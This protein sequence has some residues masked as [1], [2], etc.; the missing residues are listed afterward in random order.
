[1]LP[2]VETG[3]RYDTVPGVVVRRYTTGKRDRVV[4]SVAGVGTGQR[5][6]VHNNSLNNLMRGLAER[7]LFKASPGGLVKAPRPVSGAFNRLRGVKHLLLKHLSP[8][9]VVDLDDYPGL[10][11]GRKRVIYERAVAELHSR[12]YKDSGAEIKAFVKAEK[13]NFTAKGD[14]APRLI[15]P[16]SPVYNACLGRYLK[17]F[18]KRLF[19][20]F[21]AA[22]GYPVVL[23][24]LNADGVGRALET[25]WKSFVKPVA[26]GLDASRFDQH[27]SQEALRFEHSVYNSVFGSPELAR[28]L[29]A[30][31]RNKGIGVA[32]DGHVRYKTD[33]C[34]MSGDINTGMGNC[35]LM[36][37]MVLGYC[38]SKHLRALLS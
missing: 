12:G 32:A 31:L 24:G 17:K 35:L 7:V 26:V 27:V 30:Q 19:R 29:R 22:F 8:T 2:G 37:L 6:G 25:N 4:R 13:I 15:Q 18:E 23:K 20:G 36:S 10:Y 34:R 3:V 28:L 9:P 14:P 33:G 16:R 5:Y 38:E 1:M 21:E 11:F